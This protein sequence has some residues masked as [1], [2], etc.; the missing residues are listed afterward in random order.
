MQSMHRFIHLDMGA[1]Q[2]NQAT[3]PAIL[4]KIG[5]PSTRANVFISLGEI[6]DFGLAR[7]FAKASKLFA[8]A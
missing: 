5:P 1:E 6:V 8:K 3:E 7:E 2:T 4:S